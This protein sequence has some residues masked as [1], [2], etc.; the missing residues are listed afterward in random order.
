[1]VEKREF[2]VIFEKKRHKDYTEE[3][4]PVEVVDGMYNEK[5]EIFV[6]PKENI[7]YFHIDVAPDELL[8]FGCRTTIELMKE[9]ISNI[10]IEAIKREILSY[11]KRFTYKRNFET[12]QH[13]IAT[14][15]VT[16]NEYLFED[17]D[18][19]IY[20][21]SEDKETDE[22]VVT[23]KITLTPKEIEDRI[24][25][26]IKGQDEAIR[27]IVTALWTTINFRNMRKKNMLII[28]PTGVGKTAIF[29][30]IKE[31]LDIPVIIFAVPGLSQA[32]YRGRD[33][34]EILKQAFLETEEDLAKAETAIIILDEIDKLA[35]KGEGELNNTAVQ[36]EL[37]KIIEGCKRYVETYNM[38]DSGFTI[39][40]SK[41]IFIA[42]GAFQELYEKEKPAIGFNQQ[43][44]SLKTIDPERLISYGLKREL[45]GRLPIII[46]LN[47]LGKKE[48]KEIVLE[49]DESELKA[50][51]ESLKTFNIEIDNLGELIDLVVE[52][53]M[54]KHIGARGL[55]LTLNNIFQEIFYEVANNPDK[56]TRV[57]IGKNIINDNKDFKLIK[58]ASR[59][60]KRV[61]A[62]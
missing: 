26:T 28:G 47:S 22:T 56:Y 2:V 4:I 49:S 25:L 37:L 6:D 61:I 33:T 27:K 5:D 42:T 9:S 11:A 18:N 31:I 45:V 7:Q 24:K 62:Q 38:Y 36:N 35:K 53:A 30:K 20:R 29:N 13:I 60:K 58:T 10:L 55:I 23:E 3:F 8:G 44:K 34:D 50:T 59:T 52:D 57:I 16:G 15:R 17:K 54:S 48:L 19:V 32:G 41:M 51:I 12:N 39:D 14:D 1:M 43:P 46:E 40:T 21:E